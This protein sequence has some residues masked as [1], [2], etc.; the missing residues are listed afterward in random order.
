M[1]LLSFLLGILTLL[2]TAVLILTS[3]ADAYGGWG[4]GGCGPV[5]F[6]PT[7][8][9]VPAAPL[10]RGEGPCSALCTCGCADG[11]DCGCNGPV[12]VGRR[13]AAPKAPALVGPPVETGPPA[14]PNYGMDWHPHAGDGEHYSVNGRP[15]P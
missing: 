15:V 13:S 14:P 12:V 8:A 6:A 11:G 10:P 9:P 1:K 7:P 5:R 4:A 3:V 2:L